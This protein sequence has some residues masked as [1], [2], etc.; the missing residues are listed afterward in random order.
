MEWRRFKLA[1][2]TARRLFA[3]PTRLPALFVLLTAVPLFSL[4]W[5][6]CRVLAQDQVL[7]AQRLH[8][9]LDNAADLV[10]RE[11]A[12]SLTAWDVIA[13]GD[14]T[15]PSQLPPTALVL[16]VHSNGVLAHRG[17]Q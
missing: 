6:G 9:R 8:E 7:E 12:R 3:A 2:V 4:G 10:A 14:S 13:S 11:L 1:E 15:S 5:L 16:L 17:V